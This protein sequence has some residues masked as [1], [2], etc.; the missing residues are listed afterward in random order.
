MLG[1]GNYVLI[2]GKAAR[3][4]ISETNKQVKSSTGN[5]SSGG[6]RGEAHEIWIIICRCEVDNCVF[7]GAF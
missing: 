2:G 7:V 6:G 3:P 4:F 5:E 1:K